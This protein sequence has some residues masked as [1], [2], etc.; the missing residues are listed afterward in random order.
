[1]DS[2]N[3]L[4]RF[5][6]EFNN[7]VQSSKT[8]LCFSLGQTNKVL[9]DFWGHTYNNPGCDH[10][11][12]VALRAIKDFLKQCREE[13]SR[14]YELTMYLSFSPCAGC[15]K[16]LTAFVR[17]ESAVQVSILVSRLYFPQYRDTRENLR[18]LVHSGIRL[19][20]MGRKDFEKCHHLFVDYCSNFE[21]WPELDE[22]S[23]NGRAVL[24]GIL[25]QH[26]AVTDTRR[27]WNQLDLTRA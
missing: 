15:C 17:S 5:Y 4:D 19:E 6:Q 14:K 9:W 8:L 10:A 26:L 27:C 11:E 23:E 1:A 16:R 12:T 3:S 7:R 25:E 21:E 2:L 13:M 18:Q 24:Q 22:E 20:V